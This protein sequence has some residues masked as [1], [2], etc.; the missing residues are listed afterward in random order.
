MITVD[1]ALPSMN[2]NKSI[3]TGKTGTAV[4]HLFV[5]RLRTA[6]MCLPCG[7]RQGA[8]HRENARHITTTTHGKGTRSAKRKLSAR[9]RNGRRQ[10]STEAHGKGSTHGKEKRRRTAKGEFTAK[11]L[12]RAGWA[13]A[14][15]SN[16]CRACLSLP[17]ALLHFFLLL[18]YC[19]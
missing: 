18:H 5:V 11:S 9:Q 12:C 8:R 1:S 19:T 6:K 16:L 10:S 15:Q 2:Q 13:G 17:C 7:R 3:T 4:Q 14:R